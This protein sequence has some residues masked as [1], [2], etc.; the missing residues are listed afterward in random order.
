MVSIKL[1]NKQ[2]V[3]L[4]SPRRLREMLFFSN[5]TFDFML[6]LCKNP[7]VRSKVRTRA[8]ML[9]E[10]MPCISLF[11]TL[12]SKNLALCLWKS[13]FPLCTLLAALNWRKEI[14]GARFMLHSTSWKRR[15]IWRIGLRFAK[16]WNNAAWLIPGKNREQPINKN[17]RKQKPKRSTWSAASVI[18][19]FYESITLYVPCNHCMG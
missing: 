3:R 4:F 10:I 2:L 19:H 17:D 1:W 6:T 13:N 18:A 9:A 15:N 12:T 16:Q 11:Y 8:D 5:Y 14:Y 7:K